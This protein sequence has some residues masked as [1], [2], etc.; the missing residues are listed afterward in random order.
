MS[1]E[2]IKY[3]Q[4]EIDFLDYVNTEL[5]QDDE[6]TEAE[7]EDLDKYYKYV[8]KLENGVDNN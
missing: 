7:I 6:L 3:T 1:E 4:E 5:I 2:L 8:S